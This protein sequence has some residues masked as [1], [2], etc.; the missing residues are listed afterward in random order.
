MKD[1]LDSTT[2]P[3]TGLAHQ[4]AII[5]EPGARNPGVPFD[6]VWVDA[7]RVNQSAIER[8]I[9]SLA[10][11]RSVKQ[12]WQA[13]WLLKAVTCIDLTTLAGDDTPGRVVRLCAKARSPVRPDLLEAL[14]M[15]E[16]GLKVGAVCVYHDMISTAL[17]ALSGS[18]IPV[19]AV[20]TGFPAAHA[21][22][23][24]RLAEIEASVEAGAQ[25]IDVVIS[26]RH[27]LCGDW[28]ALYGE[29]RAF[30][31]ACGAAHVKAILAT[32]ELGSLVKVAR[33]ST[34]CMMA[35]AD[36][37]KT[38]TGMES[39]NAT[40]PVSLAMLR[41][42]RDYEQRCGIQIGFKP[43]GGISSA[44]QALAYLILLKEELGTEWMTPRLFRF[45]AS[46]LLSDIERQLEHFVTGRYSAAHRHAMG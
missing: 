17:Q 16:R 18:G 19:A 39:V 13:A 28:R 2:V 29:M 7:I 11:R 46:R 12:Q 25:E 43:A 1:P 45:G 6:P 42:V 36:F 14:G 21:P 8:R 9:D 33:A 10:G 23:S 5:R 27:V 26:R 30:R 38:S 22:M 24:T 41:T 44:K 32:G 3:G 20:S 37:V 34:V 35:G 31:A 4:G 40:L 15:T